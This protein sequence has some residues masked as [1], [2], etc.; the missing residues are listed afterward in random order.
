MLFGKRKSSDGQMEEMLSEP[1]WFGCE[2]ML[3][4]YSTVEGEIK[5]NPVYSY[6]ESSFV[7]LYKD[8]RKTEFLIPVGN[9]KMMKSHLE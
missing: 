8:E 1:M 2:V 9:V 7:R 6:G 3:D 4:D 5:N